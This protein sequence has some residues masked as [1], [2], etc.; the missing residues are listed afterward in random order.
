MSR[1]DAEGFH[2]PTTIFEAAA[3]QHSIKAECTCRHWA[4]FDSPALWWLFHRK[5]WSDD[6]A[7]AV[8]RFRC[9]A[10]DRKRARLYLVREPTTRE[11]PMPSE[12]GWRRA[13]A[14][15]RS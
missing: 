14:R 2:I 12:D 13:I 10:C 6:F 5:G 3:W 1:Y 7:D 9:T 15:F 8:R 4:V 11:L